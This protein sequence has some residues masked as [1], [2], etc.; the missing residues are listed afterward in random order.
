MKGSKQRGLS[1]KMPHSFGIIFLWLALIYVKGERD[2]EE[3]GVGEGT[4]WGE[5]RRRRKKR[6]R[7][8][9]REGRKGGMEG[10]LQVFKSKLASEN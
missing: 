10:R 3:D 5:N 8:E 4:E 7:R 9:R 6:R 2:R 1:E